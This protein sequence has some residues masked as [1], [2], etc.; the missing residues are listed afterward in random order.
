M[1]TS[2]LTIVPVDSTVTIVEPPLI[3]VA[4][5]GTV[6]FTIPIGFGSAP[7]W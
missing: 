2:I 1:A 3:A 7:A 4:L 5:S 6:T